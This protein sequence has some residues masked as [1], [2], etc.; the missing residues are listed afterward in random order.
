MSTPIT[1]FRLKWAGGKRWL[2]DALISSMGADIFRA[3]FCE[4]FAGGAALSFAIGGDGALHLADT[5]LDLI[6]TY[7]AIK[8]SPQAL[9]NELADLPID[10]DVFEQLRSNIP[11]TRLDRAVRTIYLNRTAFN[12][13]WRVNALGMFNVPYGCKPE[14]R[15]PT[16]DELQATSMVLRNARLEVKDFEAAAQGT[17]APVI[18]FDPPYTVSHNNNGFI[19]YNERIFSWADQQRLARTAS[20][21]A[22][23]GQ[24]VVVSN[25][26]HQDIRK[27]YRCGPFKLYRV[28]RATNLAAS[29]EHRGAVSELLVVSRNVR[30]KTLPSFAA[31]ID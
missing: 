11:S 30:F 14:T 31:R 1:P 19:R 25:A 3:G 12:G 13:L 17:T 9:A 2:A 27:L 7:R 10:R 5:N 15:L 24:A 28:S 6:D 26:F 22:E 8:A 20:S 21:L 23:R 29:V 18:Y 16:E 4:P